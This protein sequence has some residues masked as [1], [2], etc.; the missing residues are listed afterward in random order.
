MQDAE[1]QLELKKAH[2]NRVTEELTNKIKS[3]RSNEANN[4]SRIA[5][6]E[7]EKESLGTVGE[8]N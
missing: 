4:D 6:T 5:R 7:Q 1:Q 3:L 8:E 2:K